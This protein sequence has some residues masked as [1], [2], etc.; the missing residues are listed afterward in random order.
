MTFREENGDLFAEEI[1]KGYALGHCISSDFAL[2]AGIAKAFA[3]LGVKNSSAKSI[4]SSG[5]AGD[6]AYSPKQTA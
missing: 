3:A 5:R 4:K 2:G 6:T 1:L